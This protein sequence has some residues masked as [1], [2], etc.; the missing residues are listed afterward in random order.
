MIKVVTPWQAGL[1][2]LGHFS[3][4]IKKLFGFYCQLMADLHFAFG[5]DYKQQAALPAFS[6]APE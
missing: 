1:F 2:F 3:L 6:V 4:Q 5:T